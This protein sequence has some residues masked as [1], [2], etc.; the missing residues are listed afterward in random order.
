MSQNAMSRSL[1]QPE[2]FMEFMTRELK[3][4]RPPANIMNRIKNKE[5]Q[6]IKIAIHERNDPCPCGS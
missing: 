6:A 5:N 3:N 2:P 1:I 4:R